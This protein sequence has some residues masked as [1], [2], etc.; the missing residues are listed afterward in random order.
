M[1]PAG[2]FSKTAH[3]QKTHIIYYH[4]T[5]DK[6]SAIA[7]KIAVSCRE[8]WV[9]NTKETVKKPGGRS[10]RG[11][12]VRGKSADGKAAVHHQ[13]FAGEIKAAVHF[14]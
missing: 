7:A 9:K 10:L 4:G 13:V 6:S 11:F 12:P 5:Y 14:L 3:R 8:Q 2:V 1:Q